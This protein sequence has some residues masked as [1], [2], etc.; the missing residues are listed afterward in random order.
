MESIKVANKQID[1]V[2]I[3][4]KNVRYIL[5]NSGTYKVDGE[6]IEVKGYEK[7]QVGVIDFNDIRIVSQNTYIEKYTNGTDFKTVEEYETEK[8]TLL[9]KREVSTDYSDE[10]CWKTLE[11]EFTYKKFIQVWQPIRK[12]IQT[13]SEPIEVSVQKAKYETGNKYIESCFLNGTDKDLNMYIYNRPSAVLN[14]VKECFNELGMEYNENLN[15][16]ATEG[17]KVWSNSTHSCI[18]YVTTFGTYILGDSWDVRNSPK[19]TLNDMLAKYEYD[20]KTLRGIII[21]KYNKHFGKIE[22][23]TFDFEDLL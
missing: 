17:N 13:I 20:R 9:S 14:I 23:G 15:Y 16:G 1:G 21:G 11:D 3:T 10:Y 22:Q 6:I 19:G 18:R 5:L 12:T 4:D 8:L 2:Y 7:Q